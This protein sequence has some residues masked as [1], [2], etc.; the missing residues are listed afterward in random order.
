MKEAVITVRVS[1]HNKV[2]SGRSAACQ[3]KLQLSLQFSETGGGE[4]NK[5][6]SGATS[7]L[8]LPHQVRPQCGC[9]N[10]LAFRPDLPEVTVKAYKVTQIMEKN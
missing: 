6:C 7:Q 10:S 1:C 4:K 2:L 9:N 5:M 8:Q 3:S